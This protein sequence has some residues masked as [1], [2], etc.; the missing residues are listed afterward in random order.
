MGL[1][2]RSFKDAHK[3]RFHVRILVT[4][5]AG[6][7]GSHI[8]DAYLQAGHEVAVADNLSTGFRRNVNPQVRF[9]ETD[10][11]SDEFTRFFLSFKP[12]IV[13]HLAAQMDVRESLKRPMFDAEVNIHGT[14][15]VLEACVESK[16]KKIIFAST[17]GAIYGEPV[18]LP[19]T[20]TT[21]TAPLCHYGVSK[22]AGES[23]VTLYGRLYGLKH[24]ILRL[25]N[26]YGPRQ[27]PHG[28]AGVCSILASMILRGETPVLYG[29]GAPLRDYVYV[30]DIVRANLQALERG[31]GEVLNLGS[32]RGTSVM[33][34][35]NALQEIAG[36]SIR[37]SLASLRPGE[38]ERIYTSG[39]KAAR[40]LDW[41]PE[42]CLNDGLRRVYA[43]IARPHS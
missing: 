40:I 8:V 26:V 10:I 17:G 4:G 28:E 14:I 29:D 27:N 11:R 12:D 9:H 33:D 31:D 18:A 16:V 34:L 39:A 20:E 22:L 42:I 2:G 21:P 43:S 23:Y 41:Q 19:A 30:D 37:P 6:F 7:I 24:T 13:N 3:G 25:P 5:G 1:F 35:F 38:V 15:R 36:T 32:G